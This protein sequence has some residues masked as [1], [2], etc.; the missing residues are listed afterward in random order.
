MTKK[1]N[2][3]VVGAT[4]AVGETMLEILA[5]RK[6]PIEK[7]Y[8]LAS[9]R[10]T[11]DTVLYNNKPHLIE[12]LAEFDFSL[13]EIAL[14]SAGGDVSKEFAP[15]AA[16][17]GCIVIDNT[18][19]F[20]NEDDIPLV[21]PEVNPD[22]IAHYSNR[23]II[24]NPNCSTIQ[25][26]VA[27]KPIYDTFGIKKIDVCTY[28]SVSG[29]GKSGINELVGQTGKLL[30]GQVAEPKVFSQQI[31]FNV[32]P[33]IDVFMDNGF[34]REEMKMV[35]ETRKI[36]DDNAIVVNATAVRVPV[37]YGHSEAI[38]IETIKPVQRDAALSVLTAA[39]GVIVIDDPAQDQFATPVTHSAGNNA[40][41]VS[42]VRQQLDSDTGLNLWVVSDNIRKGAALNSIQIAEKLIEDYL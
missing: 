37:F 21:V 32:L 6:F 14:F 7:L 19:E 3:A 35:W 11:G 4:G 5:E 15:K 25:M 16:A 17:L 27:L 13:V 29:S 33:Q 42:R 8:P 39:P 9:E 20:R 12:N 28:Q 31:A 2:V 38:H 34:T 23:N 22:A 41:F 24:A 18:S 40:V 36:F 26:L 1:Y 30:N 10:S